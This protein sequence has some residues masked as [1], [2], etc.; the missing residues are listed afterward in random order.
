MEYE[1]TED[2]QIQADFARRAGQ[3]LLQYDR[4]KTLLPYDQQFEATL[5]ICLLQTI[6]TQCQEL[7]SRVHRPEKAPKGLEELVEMANRGLN[8]PPPLLGLTQ[9]CIQERWPSSNSV[10]YRD[11]IECIRNALSHPTPQKTEGYPRTGFTTQ[12]MNSGVVE[13]YIFTHSPWVESDGSLNYQFMAKLDKINE[14]ERAKKKIAGW[15]SQR[16]VSGVALEKQS[17]Q[18][19]PMRNG[20][21]FI[22]VMRVQLDVAQLRVFILALS[23]YLSEPLLKHLEQPVARSLV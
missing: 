10:R 2:A 15:T 22:P 20:K 5:G 1:R 13:S 3:I 21:I 4:C 23:D 6:L 14:V 9:A 7:L 11:L 8:D 18:F 12:K 16:G 17:N 19:L